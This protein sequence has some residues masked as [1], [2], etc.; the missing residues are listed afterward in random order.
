M[1]NAARRFG[2]LWVKIRPIHFRLVDLPDPPEDHPR[3]VEAVIHAATCSMGN[4]TCQASP[5]SLSA[6]NAVRSRVTV[7]SAETNR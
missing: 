2:A 1:S 4:A 3:L 7:S 5:F 6:V